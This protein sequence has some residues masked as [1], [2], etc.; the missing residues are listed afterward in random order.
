MGM[1]IDSPQGVRERVNFMIGDA[2]FTVYSQQNIYGLIGDPTR[3]LRQT[4]DSVA[5]QNGGWS[6]YWGLE[7]LS[8]AFTAPSNVPLPYGFFGTT[9]RNS[10]FMEFAAGGGIPGL[11]RFARPGPAFFARDGPTL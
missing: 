1:A 2:Q 6:Q 3:T 9:T 7:G 5:Q 4:T 8:S 10:S 11:S